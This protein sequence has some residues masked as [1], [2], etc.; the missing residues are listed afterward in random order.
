MP[1]SFKS[2]GLPSSRGSRSSRS[3]SRG[4]KSMFESKWFYALVAAV[5]LV[6]AILYFFVMPVERFENAEKPAS[7]SA[8]NPSNPSMEYFYLETCPH[9]VEFAPVWDDAVAAF[10][11]EGL[12]VKTQKYDANDKDTG[13]KARADFFGVREFP[14]VLYVYGPAKTDKVEYNGPRTADGLVAFVKAR[15]TSA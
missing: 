10:K 2:R 6:S 9:C 8:S 1:K 4:S 12:N 15:M 13:G 3:L 11:K 14:T 5:L 7:A